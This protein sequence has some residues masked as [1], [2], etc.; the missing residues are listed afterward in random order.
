MTEVTAICDRCGARESL[1]C[2]PEQAERDM[3]SMGWW[4]RADGSRD[5]CPN[6]PRPAAGDAAAEATP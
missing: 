2:A 6:H 3:E 5:L 4:L 1:K